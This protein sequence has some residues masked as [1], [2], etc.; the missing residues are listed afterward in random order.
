MLDAQVLESVSPSVIAFNEQVYAAWLQ[1]H[2]GEE[3]AR[4]RMQN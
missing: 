4:R 2:T 3:E 1:V